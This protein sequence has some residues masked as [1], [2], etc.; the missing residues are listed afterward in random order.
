MIKLINEAG[1][2]THIF[3]SLAD[4][5]EM[6]IQAMSKESFGHFNFGYDFEHHGIGSP[7]KLNGVV[8]CACDGPTHCA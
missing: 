7:L 3:L 4:Y 5:K 6:M 8:V 2:P 1:R